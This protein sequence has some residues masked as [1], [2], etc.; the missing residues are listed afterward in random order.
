MS[1]IE[2]LNITV[3]VRCRG[4]NQ[5]EVEARSSV[6]VR[7][8]DVT[9]ENEV[10]INTSGETGI[11]AHLNSKTYTVDKVFGPSADQHLVF[12]SIAEP[13]FRDFL[14]GYN[15]T[16]LVYGM[17]STGKT[18]T[19]TG[20]ER[21][22]DGELS[23]AAGIIPRVLFKVFDALEDANSDDYMIKCSFVELYNEELK[24]LLDEAHDSNNNVPKKLRI[25]DSP[26][27][28]NNGNSGSRTN[29]RTNSPKIAESQYASSMA[30]NYASR[31]RM[32]MGPTMLPKSARTALPK[33]SSNAE[34]SSAIHIQ[35]LQEFHIMSAKEGIRLL[36]RGLKQRQVASTKMNDFSSRS[37]T[38]FTIMLYKKCDDE[39]FR[40]SKMNL[41]DLAG[42]ENINRSGAQNQRAK[43]AGSINQSLLTLGRVINSLADKNAHIPFRESKLT[44]LL[45]DSLGGNTKTALIATI[46]P[47]KI[48]SEETSS[49]LEYASKAKN[50]KNKPQ[51]GSFIMKDV[52]VKSITAELVK[53]KSDLLSTKSKDGVYMSQEN[54][55]ELTNELENYKTEVQECQRSIER[56]NT[57]NAI[58]L[59]ERKISNELNES[60]KAKVRNLGDN[61]EYLYDK[62][63]RQH[64]NEQELSNVVQELMRALH[65]MRQSLQLYEDQGQRFQTEMEKVL[66][67]NVGSFKKSLINEIEKLK[68]NI[69]EDSIDV[70]GNIKLVSQEL[71]RIFDRLNSSSNEISQKFVQ[72]IL[73]DSPKHFQEIH[74]QVENI[75]SVVEAYSSSLITH[76]SS[77]SEEYN[78][79]K[80]YLNE[81]FF[82]NNFQEALDV[83]V[84]RTYHQLKLSAN[85]VFM[86]LRE[87]MNEHLENNKISMIQSLKSAAAE[88]VE[89]EMGLLDPVKTAWEKSLENINDC[90][91]LNNKFE[92]DMRSAVKEVYGRIDNAAGS[93]N[94]ALVE[95]ENDLGQLK[96]VSANF[97]DNSLIQ[98]NV[99]GI[100]RKHELLKVQVQNSADYMQAATQKFGEIDQSIQD[101]LSTQTSPQLNNEERIGN[102]L[103]QLND[104]P[105]RP[106]GPSGKTPMRIAYQVGRTSDVVQQPSM[107]RSC[108]TSPIKEIDG[109]RRAPSPLK[110]RLLEDD[111]SLKAKEIE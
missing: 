7:V 48:N 27:N 61:I 108:S 4:R 103:E 11:A 96:D 41:V 47:A 6:V 98:N 20:D 102:L 22:Y 92:N 111:I 76:L 51:V 72:G 53:I 80:D 42:S 50:I 14:K 66:Y 52:L 75:T 67:E 8:P 35:N 84:E 104:R 28:T 16:V 70:D 36:Q 79:L 46:S 31:R 83:H 60:Q 3:A 99:E 85:S 64:K 12:K 24:D 38:V 63:D 10:S 17:T 91:K 55:K 88:V 44:R 82:K 73:R 59:K 81:Q 100:K 71:S 5:K 94:A 21:L 62:I 68:D 109:N 34:N 23:Q 106:L 65:V 1:D 33:S 13:L 43:E 45:Q 30:S 93:S 110:R 69:D 56:V 89:K 97:R 90:D 26:G 95:I 37:H 9:G 49:T 2:E 29:S 57:Q 58:L 86:S 87:I 18:Y 32:R 19:M 40:V 77:I 54:Y 39:N 101:L 78:N 74:S 105:L 107:K 25:F 15:C